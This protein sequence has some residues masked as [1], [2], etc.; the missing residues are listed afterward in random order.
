MAS[1]LVRGSDNFDMPNDYNGF[2]R[3]ET[4]DYNTWQNWRLN[5]AHSGQSLTYAHCQSCNPPR[6]ADTDLEYPTLGLI[7]LE[8]RQTRRLAPRM[9]EGIARAK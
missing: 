3:C 5:T 9:V 8:P 6:R 1:F 7:A 4:Q 2:A